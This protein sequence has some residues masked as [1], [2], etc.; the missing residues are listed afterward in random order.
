[1]RLQR[2]VTTSAVFKGLNDRETGA[3]V[4]HVRRLAESVTAEDFDFES[5]SNLLAV[6]AHLHR[7][8]IQLARSNAWIT[9]VAQRF[10]VSKASTD[11][12]CMAAQGHEPHVAL[13]RAGHAHVGHL[14]EQA[15][16]HSVKGS[17]AA[18]ARSLMTRGSK[19]L[20]AKLVELAGVVRSRHAAKIDGSV[21]MTEK[22]DELKRRSCSKGT[23]VA[24]GGN[25]NRA[26]AALTIRS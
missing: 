1:V 13:I 9:K 21:A 3:C 23:Q 14:S 10:C 17:H 15:M 22:V 25:T 4:G 12:L 6:L 26:A 20:N 8:E 7:T 24:L 19:T 5:A 11:M 18:A 2:F 16:A